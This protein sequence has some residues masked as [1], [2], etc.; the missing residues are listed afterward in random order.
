MRAMTGKFGRQA[1]R[2]CCID[3]G[4][5][6]HEGMTLGFGSGSTSLSDLTKSLGS[7]GPMIAKKGFRSGS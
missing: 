2:V 4:I 3:K 1:H 5:P 6:T 7:V